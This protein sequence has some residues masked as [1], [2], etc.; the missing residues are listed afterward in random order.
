MKGREGG[1]G[2]GCGVK[3]RADFSGKKRKFSVKTVWEKNANAKKIIFGKN[4]V[5]FFQHK[6]FQKKNFPDFV[7]IVCNFK[8]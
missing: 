4:P 1:L 2:R 5:Q 7:L 8:S 3:R 6:R